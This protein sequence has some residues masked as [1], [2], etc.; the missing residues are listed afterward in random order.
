MRSPIPRD[1][2]RKTVS[3]QGFAMISCFLE[4][5]AGFR[6]RPSRVA[7]CQIVEPQSLAVLDLKG[8]LRTGFLPAGAYP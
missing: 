7:K 8:N 6:R 5:N 3:L 2:N 1:Y 4:V